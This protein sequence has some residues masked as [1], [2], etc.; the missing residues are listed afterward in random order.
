MRS[1]FIILVIL[2]LA[3]Q[4]QLWKGV[5]DVRALS[6]SV[7]EQR[8]DNQALQAH[9]EALFAEVR[10]LREGLEAIEERARAE[11]GL[12]GPDEDFYLLIDPATAPE[13]TRSQPPEE[14]PL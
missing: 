4:V 2:L 9:N 3:V 8:I 6:A 14:N 13:S 1:I 10:D 7:A 5:R 11:W 12:V